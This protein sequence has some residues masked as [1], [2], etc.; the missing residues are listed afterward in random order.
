MLKTLLVADGLAMMHCLQG[1]RLYIVTL[2]VL[3]PY[4]GLG[5]GSRL[6]QRCM[7]MVEV[8]GGA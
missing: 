8:C 7:D 6:L 3:A 1:V 5:V 2:G 4:R